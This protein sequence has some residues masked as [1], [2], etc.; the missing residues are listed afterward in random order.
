MYLLDFQTSLQGAEISNTGG[1]SKESSVKKLQSM[2]PPKDLPMGPPKGMPPAP[3][4]KIMPPPSSKCMP[5]PHTVTVESTPKS[6]IESTPKLDIEDSLHNGTALKLVEYGEEDEEDLSSPGSSQEN[7][8][9][10]ANGKPFW[11]L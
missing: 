8:K 2:P 6:N 7:G 4:S 3:L 9:P 5:P 11:A 1:L 10:Y